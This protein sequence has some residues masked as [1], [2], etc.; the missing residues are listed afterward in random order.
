MRDEII[1][2][3]VTIR[4]VKTMCVDITGSVRNMNA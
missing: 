2:L 4:E 3:R 1:K